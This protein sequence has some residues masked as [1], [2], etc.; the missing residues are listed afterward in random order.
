MEQFIREWGYLALFLY[1][2]GGG[3]V[4]L[5]IAGILSATGDMNIFISIAVAGSS[6]FLGDTFLFYIAKKNKNYTKD[7]L[8]KHR[9]K[10]ALTR[11]LIRKYGWG[12]IILQKYI[13]GIKTL[14]PIIIALTNYSFY[15]FTIFNLIGTIIWA[16]VIGYFAYYMGDTFLNI[17][18]EYKNYIIAG[19]LIFTGL[20]FYY[21]KLMSRKKEK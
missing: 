16:L 15:K 21:L 7:I 5:V 9:K 17:A 19:V 14:I 18:N 2:F 1:S 8:N 4:G 11:L 3:F 6:N 13:Y 12:S 10:I 20:I